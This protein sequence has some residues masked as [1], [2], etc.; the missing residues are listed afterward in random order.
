M[1]YGTFETPIDLLKNTLSGIQEV[2]SYFIAVSNEAIKN[3]NLEVKERVDKKIDHLNQR[4]TEYKEAIEKI[5]D[6]TVS[7]DKR[8]RLKWK[9]TEEQ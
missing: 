3:E 7:N 6:I 5:G 2:R 9:I 8:G 1:P 4:E